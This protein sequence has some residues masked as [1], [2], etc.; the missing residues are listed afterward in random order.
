LNGRRIGTAVVWLIASVQKPA[1]VPG[2]ILWKK[3]TANH[4][5]PSAVVV[6]QLASIDQ[7]GLL[8]KIGAWSAPIVDQVI[9]GC[10]LV[11]YRK[12]S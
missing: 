6:S 10:P 9:A 4:P 5:R 3:T 12:T 11:R 1:R 8:Q 2:N 7:S